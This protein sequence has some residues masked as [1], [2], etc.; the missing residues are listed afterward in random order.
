MRKWNQLNQICWQTETS[1]QNV[2]YVLLHR[3]SH[4]LSWANR[5]NSLHISLKVSVKNCGALAETNGTNVLL[6][7]LQKCR[8]RSNWRAEFCI[9]QIIHTNTWYHS[10][11]CWSVIHP[12]SCSLHSYSRSASMKNVAAAYLKLPFST[13]ESVCTLIGSTCSVCRQNIES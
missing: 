8:T 9:P 4:C 7:L 3:L 2:C 10:T 11:V 12:I 1:V 13:L 5:L 6:T